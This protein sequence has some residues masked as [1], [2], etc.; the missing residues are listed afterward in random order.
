MVTASMS[1]TNFGLFDGAL[2]QVLL[3]VRLDQLTA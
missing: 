1:H 3:L 2:F